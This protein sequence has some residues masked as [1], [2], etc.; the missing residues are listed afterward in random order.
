MNAAHLRGGVVD[1]ADQPMLEVTGVH[2]LLFPL[3]AQ[4]HLDRIAGPFHILRI[5]VAAHP[6]GVEVA[7]PPLAGAAQ[8]MGKE[9]A[10]PVAEDQVGDDLRLSGIDL[11]LVP[12]AKSM[13]GPDGVEEVIHVAIAET[14]PLPVSKQE[15]SRND[16]DV[17]AGRHLKSLAGLGRGL[18]AWR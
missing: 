2:D 14:L 18:A 6:Q 16:H 13:A 8:P 17:L 11:H 9:I 7:E 1:G 5:D 12:R 4:A 10:V 3:A 15:W